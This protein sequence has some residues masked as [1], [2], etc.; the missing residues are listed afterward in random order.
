MKS[1]RSSARQPAREP[2]EFLIDRSLGRLTIAETLRAAGLTVH[3]LADLYGEEQSRGVADVE[4]IALAA[5]WG[6]VVLCKDNRIRRR[7]AERVALEEGRVRVFCLVNASLNFAD[8]AAYFVE[9]RNRI[10]Q[11]CR[12]PGP[13]LYGVYKD[14]IKKLWPVDDEPASDS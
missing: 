6:L 11:A 3:T 5:E 4:W 1:K 7:P 12:K 13:F 2:L 10:I 9:N 14:N 8:Q